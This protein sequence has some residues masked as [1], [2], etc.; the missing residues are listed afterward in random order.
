M[1]KNIKLNDTT[2]S[3]VSTVQLPTSDG[4]SATFKDTDE[5]TTPSGST[6]ITENGTHD[7]SNFASAIVNV[8]GG[9]SNIEQGTF[10]GD[11][12]RNI[13]IPVNGLKSNVLIV[14][15]GYDDIISDTETGDCSLLMFFAN[16]DFL[17]TTACQ[18]ANSNKIAK[19]LS[20]DDTTSVNNGITFNEESID[21]V[22]LT[23][24]ASVIV[25]SNRTYTWYVW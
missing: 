9:S 21:I 12:T 19:I 8:A 7:V 13:S 16:S 10:I 5:I 14:T 1:S 23:V 6:T 15:D 18:H 25:R 20:I 17:I 24:G 22:S 3:G 11:D 2:Y 4:G